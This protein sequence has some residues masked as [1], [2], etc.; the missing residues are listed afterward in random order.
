MKT[1][2]KDIISLVQRLLSRGHLKG[3]VRAGLVALM[4][5]LTPGTLMA[6]N[7]LIDGGG[8]IDGLPG[9]LGKVLTD[10]KPAGK[11][12]VAPPAKKFEV[13]PEGQAGRK[14]NGFKGPVAA[15]QGPHV[16]DEVIVVMRGGEQELAQLASDYSLTIREQRFLS[17]IGGLFV[18]LGIPDGRPVALVR[19]SLALD[20]LVIEATPNHIFELNA[21]K[22]AIDQYSLKL[23]GINKA[24]EVARGRGVRIGI[25][26]TA[27]DE[28]H[29]ALSGGV[30]GTFDGLAKIP[31]R[32]T[33]HGTTVAVLAA[34][35][36]E[37]FTGAAP[38]ASLFIARAFDKGED[39]Q[40]INSVYAILLG[41][42]WALRQDVDIINMSFSG[43]RNELMGQAIANLLARQVVLV[44]A[45]GNG[46]PKAPFS[47]PGA[48]DGVFAVTAVDAKNRIYA[49][50]NH[51]PYVFAA[52]PGVD[53]MVPSRDEKL[54]FKSGTSYGAAIFSG[55]CALAL[56]GAEER[57]LSELQKRLIEASQDLGSP[58]RDRVF[59]FGL[60]RAETM[61]GL[62][63]N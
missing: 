48:F 56:E 57:N 31:L 62:E 10:E 41:L 24:H 61:V 59:G 2:L 5:L 30:A 26:D 45:A 51:G 19:A 39:G 20:P 50:A 43:P 46:G 13:K 1:R 16:A 42:D 47:F 27:V 44:A 6:Q 52:A 60:L 54:D 63:K 21:E 53:L 7:C 55:I 29:P 37:T 18:R 58:G 36:G 9:E 22:S 8:V 28:T 35:G 3:G 40:P 38:E 32:D 25:I 14:L 17:I 4:F 33:Q 49:K 15:V 11:I 23:T 12:C 34:G